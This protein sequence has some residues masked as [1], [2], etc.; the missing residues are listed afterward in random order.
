MNMKKLLLSLAVITGLSSCRQRDNT[1]STN[2]GVNKKDARKER[3]SSHSALIPIDSAN[4]MILSYLTSTDFT[5]NDTDLQSLIVDA[6]PIRE[7]FNCYSSV[8]SLKIMLAHKQDYINGGMFGIPAGYTRNALTVVVTGVDEAGDYVVFP[9]GTALN[10]SMP[11]P[12][13]CPQ[14]SA[15]NALIVTTPGL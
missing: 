11:C 8:V 9:G 5:A 1:C 10:K 6:A 2:V 7:L 13:S 12:T 15:A 14:G 3:T 4:K